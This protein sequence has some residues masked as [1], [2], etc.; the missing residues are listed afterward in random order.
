METIVVERT[1]AEPLDLATLREDREGID[2]CLRAYQ[3][4]LLHSYVA[5]DG[6]RMICVYQAPDAESVRQ[7]LRRVGVLPWDQAWKARVLRPED[8]DGG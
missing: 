8:I 1:L 5:P 3:V 2:A 7:A 6:R 4:S